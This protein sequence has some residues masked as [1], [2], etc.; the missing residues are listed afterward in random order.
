MNLIL[1]KE[2]N[3]RDKRYKKRMRQK[4]IKSEK[5]RTVIGEQ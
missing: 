2:I 3:N 1:R 4:K 5:Q